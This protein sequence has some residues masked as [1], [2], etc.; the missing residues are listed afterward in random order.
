M[1]L[2]KVDFETEAIGP[3]PAYPPIPVGVAIQEPGKKGVYLAWGHP[4]GNNCTQEDARRRLL[5]YW[6]DPN[7]KL[8][9]HNAKFDLAVAWERM[10]LDLPP[11]YRVECSMIAA[12][13]TDP[14]SPVLGLKPLAIKW[15]DEKADARDELKDWIIA[16]VPEAKRAKTQWGAYISKAPGNLVGKYAKDD[17]SFSGKL[18]TH[19]KRQFDKDLQKAYDRELQLMDVLIK[20]EPEG[21]AVDVKRLTK[22]CEFYSGHLASIETWLCKR[23]KVKELNFDA[24]DDLADALQNAGLVTDWILTEKG[25]RST[26]ASNLAMC[27]NDK[28]LVG[29][30][31]YRSVLS[32]CLGT[33]MENWLEVAKDGGKIFPQWQQVRSDR[34]FGARTG[35]LSCTPSL[36]NIPVHTD[37][38]NKGRPGGFPELPNVRA[39]IVPDE[40]DHV[41]IDRDFNSQEMRIFSHF[42]DGPLLQGYQK[43]PWLDSHMLVTDSVNGLMRADFKRRAGKALNFGMLYGEGIAKLAG[44]LGT[45]YDMAKQVRN[46]Y[47]A[48]FPGVKDLMDDMKARANAGM[49]IRTL[50]GRRYYCEPPKIINGR[51]RHFDYKL[52][53]YL[54]QGSAADWTKQSIIDYYH[55]P[56]RRGNWRL[57]VHDQNTASVNKKI[58]KEEMLVLQ[59]SMDK[60]MPLDCPM[61]TNGA[62]GP[63]FFDLKDLPNGY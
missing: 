61:L 60:A 24:P 22:D 34:G 43:D 8:V 59:E 32:T 5:S 40:K 31:G 11:W 15:L 42:E 62:Y 47:F 45:D 10:G 30:L 12:F 38:A 27:V 51:T 13:L 17:V 39:Y 18:L 29:A 50:G 23:L 35:R 25:A 55:H 52:I 26:A 28:E 56:K 36:M 21:V 44:G 48:L 19:C 41:Y 16:N 54:V 46:A 14:H 58:W 20:V 3:R 1:R 33:F 49:P 2:V 6:T 37:D 7:V 57:T 4:T 53:N 63:N 9:F